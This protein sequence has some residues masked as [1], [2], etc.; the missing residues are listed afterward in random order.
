MLPIAIEPASQLKTADITERS[1]AHA[2]EG[3]GTNRLR[4]ERRADPVPQPVISNEPPVGGSPTGD[5][6]GGPA[7]PKHSDG[8]VHVVAEPHS[9]GS[10]LDGASPT[11]DDVW[12]RTRTS[13]LLGLDDRDEDLG[14][15]STEAPDRLNESTQLAVGSPASEPDVQLNDNRQETEDIHR[16]SGELVDGDVAAIELSRRL[17]V[18]NLPYNATE[19]DIRQVFTSSGDIEEVRIRSELV[20]SYFYS[21]FFD[22]HLIGTAY[23]SHVML[24]EKSILVDASCC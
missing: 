10:K 1:N 19:D 13:R 18:R 20:R 11:P 17:F 6:A 22:E 5:G 14:A 12:L 24:P 2:E 16:P 4:M 7:E 23:A 8:P 9:A 15:N 21:F 3:Q